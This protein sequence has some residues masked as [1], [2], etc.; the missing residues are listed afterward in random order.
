MDF[1]HALQELGL[2]LP[3]PAYL[4]GLLLFGIVGAVAWWHGKRTQ[5][6]KPKWMGLALM[7]YPYATPQT[8]LLY[9]VGAALTGWAC[10]SWNR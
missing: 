5:R 8:W 1:L 10:W 2:E 3:T 7:L 9:A 6:P 4:I